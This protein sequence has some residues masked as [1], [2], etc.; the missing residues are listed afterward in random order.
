MTQKNLVIYHANCTDGFGAAY[1]AWKKL[2]DANTEYLPAKYGDAL[3]DVTDRHVYIVDFSYPPEQM[4]E[5]ASKCAALVILDHHKKAIELLEPVVEQMTNMLG[6]FCTAVLTTEHSGAILAW[7]Y[8]HPTTATPILLR[9]IEDRD[10]WRFNMQGTRELVAALYSY[11]MEFAVWDAIV[12]SPST[13]FLEGAALGRQGAQHVAA[14]ATHA[15]PMLIGGVAVPT[16]NAPH[17]M[18]SELGHEL[19]KGLNTF[20]AVY[21]DYA[22]CRKFSLRSDGATG[23]DVDIVAR[24]YGG[25]GHRNAAGFTVPLGWEGDQC[26]ETIP[27]VDVLPEQLG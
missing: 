21:I 19:S 16:V 22:D 12:A 17:Y 3:P 8:F 14:A 11:P 13:L 26:D 27:A 7:D 2:G 20:A 15:R 10:L 4:L 18:A 9:H 1:A 24:Q 6:G 5:I 25:G 23:Q